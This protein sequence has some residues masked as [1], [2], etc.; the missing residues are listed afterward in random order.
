MLYFFCC[1]DTVIFGAVGTDY[2][3]VFMIENSGGLPVYDRNAGI[4]SIV[5]IFV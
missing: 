3:H 2:H 5:F 4:W 1:Q